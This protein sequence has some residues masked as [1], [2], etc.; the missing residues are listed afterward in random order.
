MYNYFDQNFISG[1]QWNW[2]NAW[3]NTVYDGWN[4]EDY[5]IMDNLGNLRINFV[6]RPYPRAIAGIPL[7]FQVSYQ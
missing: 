4:M 5:S 7:S 3:D 2:H 1:T 6:I